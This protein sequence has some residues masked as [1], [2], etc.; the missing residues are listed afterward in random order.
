MAPGAV[1]SNPTEPPAA[2][3]AFRPARV[4]RLLG[5]DFAAEEQRDLLARVG[6]ETAPAPAGTRIQV[7]GGTRPLEVD[8]GDVEVIEAV[9]P[10]WRRDL[11][12]G[13][14]LCWTNSRIAQLARVSRA[15]LMALQKCA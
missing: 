13:C 15:R 6:I 7:A 3:V 4:N 10:T 1:D 2:R 8:P 11:G 12:G 5:T 14:V 9:V